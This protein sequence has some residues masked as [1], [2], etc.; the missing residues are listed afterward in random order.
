MNGCNTSMSFTRYSSKVSVTLLKMPWVVFKRS[1]V[2]SYTWFLVSRN[3]F[4]PMKIGT[5]SQQKRKQRM[6]QPRFFSCEA[7]PRQIVSSAMGLV[8][9]NRQPDTS[10]AHR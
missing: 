4:N 6:K 8:V 10:L 1:L 9:S 2:S 7:V 5:M 3:R